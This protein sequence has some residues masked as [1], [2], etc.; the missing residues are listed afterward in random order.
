MLLISWLGLRPQS[1]AG[2]G[3]E[4]GSFGISEDFSDYRGGKVVRSFLNRS[5]L[6]LFACYPRIGGPD[7]TPSTDTNILH[8][9]SR[10][11]ARF[12]FIDD[13]VCV[14]ISCGTYPP[15]RDGGIAAADEAGGGNIFFPH[16]AAVRCRSGYVL[17]IEGT[18]APHCLDG[19]SFEQGKR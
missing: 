13:R 15:P 10:Q 8:D 14:P 18:A 7:S 9:F 6:F 19:G 5:L 4:G 11:L 1:S 17:T 3:I 16:Q 12:S 2:E